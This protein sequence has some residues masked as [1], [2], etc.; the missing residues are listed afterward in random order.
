V[1]WRRLTLHACSVVSTSEV[2]PFKKFCVGAH[3]WS[4][5]EPSSPLSRLRLDTRFLVTN[6]KK[7]NARVPYENFYCQWLFLRAGA[8]SLMPG[9]RT[10]TLKHS[11]WRIA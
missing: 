7:R 6:L 10:S 4:R 1:A 11:M 2:R 9:L 5:V 8:S 3:N